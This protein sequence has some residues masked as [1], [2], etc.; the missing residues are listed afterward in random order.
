MP[1]FFVCLNELF[2]AFYRFKSHFWSRVLAAR[3]PFMDAAC[4]DT[5]YIVDSTLCHAV[6]LVTSTIVA[7]LTLLAF[8][9]SEPHLNLWLSWLLAPILSEVII[10]VPAPVLTDV[11][12]VSTITTPPSTSTNGSNTDSVEHREFDDLLR[13]ADK[14]ERLEEQL[15]EHCGQLDQQQERFA[16][17]TN[18]VN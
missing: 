12:D 4:S 14:I 13:E 5:V 6:R 8:Q 15:T 10:C 3:R 18:R 1:P 9:R 11:M 2:R 7:A 16:H 17:M